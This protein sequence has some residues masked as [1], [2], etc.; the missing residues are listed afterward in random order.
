MKRASIKILAIPGSLREKSSSNVIMYAAK[1]LLP[2]NVEIDFYNGISTL[3]HFDDSDK[4][5]ESIT[6]LRK[7]LAEADGILICTPEYAF[8]VPG[9]LKNA[10][11]WTVGSG[12]LTNKPVAVVTAAS[13][14]DKAH[15]ALLLILSALSSNVNPNA[16]LLIPFIRTKV[17]NGEVVDHDVLR[18]LQ[19][20][21][22]SLVQTIETAKINL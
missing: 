5:P 10:L 19:S 6:N 13:G 2:E 11:D 12:E 14:G 17:K 4:T 15:A 22:L 18:Q 21:L 7:K 16:T 1:H 3:P 9:S 8:G 20:V